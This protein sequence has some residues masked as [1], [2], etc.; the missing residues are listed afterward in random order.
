MIRFVVATIILILV[1]ACSSGPPPKAAKT[2]RPKARPTHVCQLDPESTLPPTPPQLPMGDTVRMVHYNTYPFSD[3]F[4]S[5]Q[6]LSDGTVYALGW[7]KYPKGP[8]ACGPHKQAV[9]VLRWDG[10]AWRPLPEFDQVVWPQQLT[11][12]ADGK[13]WVFGRCPRNTARGCAAA[14]DGTAWTVTDFGHDWTFEVGATVTGQRIWAGSYERIWEWDG[15]NSSTRKAPIPIHALAGGATDEV[16]IAGMTDGHPALARWNGQ[17]WSRPPKPQIPR[18]YG[19][20]QGKTEPYGLAVGD[21]GE[22]WMQ[23]RMYWICGEEESM[24]ARPLLLKWAAGRWT[25]TVMP[26]K[27]RLG[28]IVSDG[29]GGLWAIRNSKLARYF[30]GRWTSYKVPAGPYGGRS[31][32]RLARAPGQATV[33][34]VGEDHT[35]SELMPFTNGIIWRLEIV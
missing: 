12:T 24:C 10:T 4:T 2:K 29:T 15:T 26:E 23:A 3:T 21:N 19:D 27:S 34:A 17:S 6:A 25:V 11:A 18:L 13:V 33:W 28:H 7:R 31:V 1:A 9:V 32:M 14:W 22:V 30:G 35:E 8:S 16:W 20:K 5:V